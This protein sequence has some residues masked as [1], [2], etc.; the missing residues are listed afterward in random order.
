M[1]VCRVRRSV[2]L[3][4]RITRNAYLVG[5]ILAVWPASVKRRL[6]CVTDD[7]RWWVTFLW[8]ALRFRL[9]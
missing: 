5:C 8:A 7:I 9:K 3:R 4:G 6:L 1:I 2:K